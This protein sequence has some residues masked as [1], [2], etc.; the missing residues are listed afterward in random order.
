MLLTQHVVLLCVW[1]PTRWP[2]W[3]SAW[4]DQNEQ[5]LQ[6]AAAQAKV[7]IVEGIDVQAFTDSTP[8]SVTD[9]IGDRF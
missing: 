5:G 9:L 2:D 8:D 4:G 7:A 6:Q 1:T 3:P